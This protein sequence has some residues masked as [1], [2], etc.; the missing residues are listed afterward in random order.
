MTRVT[1]TEFQRHPGRYQDRAALTP[2][3]I[4][5]NGRERLVLLS[6]DEYRRLKSSAGETTTPAEPPTLESKDDVAR[7][8]SPEPVKTDRQ[9]AR[10]ERALIARAERIAKVAR[11]IAFGSR[12]RGDA[13]HHSDLDVAVSCPTA[14]PEQWVRIYHELQD[15]DTLL[16]IDLHRLEDASP[17]FRSQIE[18]EGRVIYG[19]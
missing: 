18:R 3:V 13:R 5:K 10:A 17:E 16:V 19:Q 14:T 6:V 8:R 11:M 7:P 12:A 9:S 4:T 1:A 2:V 15:A